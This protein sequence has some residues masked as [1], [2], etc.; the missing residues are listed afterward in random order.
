MT[1]N[2]K[3]LPKF[4]TRVYDIVPGDK[5]WKFVG[6]PVMDI[7]I[8]LPDNKTY[9]EMEPRVV[10]YKGPD[11]A[12]TVFRFTGAQIK[13]NKRELKQL[14]RRLMFA[15]NGLVE[16]VRQVVILSV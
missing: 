4:K 11:E 8:Y 6:L 12:E 10:S 1:T 13:P 14:C 3:K 5:P 2:V 16:F 9:H 7:I 15:K